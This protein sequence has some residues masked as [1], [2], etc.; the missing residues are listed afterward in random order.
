MPEE[1]K[2]QL[3]LSIIAAKQQRYSFSTG[4]RTIPTQCRAPSFGG[5]AK[6]IDVSRPARHHLAATQDGS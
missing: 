1:E 3:A 5:T 6:G 2:R 4:R